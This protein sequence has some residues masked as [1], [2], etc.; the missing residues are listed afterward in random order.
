MRTRPLSQPSLLVTVSLFILNGCTHHE[1]YSDSS[2]LAELEARSGG[3]LG[4][5]VLDTATGQ[6][7]GL[8]PAER[9]GMCSTFKLP[10]A[11]V[12]LHEADHGRMDL[13]KRIP[14]T[15]SDLVGHAP[16]TNANLARGSL[17]IRELAEAAQVTS[18]NG[19]ANL[20]LRELGG[21][22]AFTAKLGSF[23]DSVSRLDHLEP[24]MNFV[25]PG[26]IHNTTTPEAMANL[27]AR[28]LTTDAILTTASRTTLIEWM[29]A[30]ETGLARLRAGLPSDWRAGDK[31]GTGITPSLANKTNDIAIAWP[32]GQA[33]LVITAY[34]ES[35]SYFEDI[36]DEDQAVL[37]EVGRIA[38]AWRLARRP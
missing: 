34:Y 24:A 20:L 36:R 3:R 21:P 27:V 22:A 18:D 31:T 38:A 1:S 6:S 37:A 14:I 7:I 4:A 23:G 26:E 19:A 25:R 35:P 5:F 30:T 9:F 10:L 16:V 33:P 2:S 17:T 28:A 13:E 29:V 32:P 15:E 12:V 8:R 11:I